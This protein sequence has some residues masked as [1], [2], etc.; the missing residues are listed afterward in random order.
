MRDLHLHHCS[1]SQ[2]SRACE[3]DPRRDPADGGD[4]VRRLVRLDQ[5]PDCPAAAALAAGRAPR[6]CEACWRALRPRQRRFCGRKCK[7]AGKGR[8]ALLFARR[9]PSEAPV[10]WVRT[11]DVECLRA[12]AHHELAALIEATGR[13]PRGWSSVR[14][15]WREP[16]PRRLALVQA[17]S[18]ARCGVRLSGPPAQPVDVVRSPSAGSG[19]AAAPSRETPR[20]SGGALRE[21]NTGGLGSVASTGIKPV[22]RPNG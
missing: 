12:G 3:L 7:R 10:S 6:R 19:A 17:L 16:A 21:A 8:Q 9:R 5:E 13:S 14:D 15:L 22:E 18:R 1:E 20:T 2:A 4:V 11:M